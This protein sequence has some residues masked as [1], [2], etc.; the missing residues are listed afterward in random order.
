MLHLY[1]LSRAVYSELPGRNIP[2]GVS[3]LMFLGGRDV[4]NVALKR[5]FSY[6]KWHVGYARSYFNGRLLT[7]KKNSYIV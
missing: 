6:R 2:V 1:W 3:Q 7:G 5:T 4:F